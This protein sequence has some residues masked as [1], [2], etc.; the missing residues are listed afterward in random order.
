MRRRKFITLLG[1]AVAWPLG[2]RA[3]QLDQMRRIG[4]LQALA[5]SDPE[6]QARTL[7][8]RQALD[9]LGW[10][11]GRNIRIDY[12]FAGGDS[13]RIQTYAAELV[14]SVPDLIVAHSSPVVAALKQATS[15]IPIVFSLIIDPV[16]QSFVASLA[17]PGG[18][19]TGFTYID[20][21]TIGKLLELLKEIAPGVRRMTLM[22]SPHTAP[23][24]PLALGELGPALAS[25][26]VEFSKTPVHDEAEIEAAI[27]AFAREPGGGLIV[28]PEPFMNAHRTLVITL[29]ERY[30]LPAIYGFRGFVTEGALISYGADTVDISALLCSRVDAANRPAEMGAINSFSDRSPTCGAPRLPP[31]NW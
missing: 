25:L 19:I 10:T 24:V 13:H 14:N 26:A 4:F 6:A 31:L 8:F 28:T 9:A 18:N 29:A 27:T 17:R 16:G 11:E 15:T 20:F 7:A 30:Q 5:E 2:A 21:P 1:G 23:W 22:F 3:Q 12:R